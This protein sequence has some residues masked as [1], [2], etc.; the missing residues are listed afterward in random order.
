[1]LTTSFFSAE[2]IVAARDK[3]RA[4][5]EAV[6]LVDSVQDRQG[7]KPEVSTLQGKWLEI[8]WK[9]KHK[10]THEPIL[11]WCAG[12][13]VKVA[14][15]VNDMS[16]NRQNATVLTSNTVL[17]RWEADAEFEEEEQQAWFVLQPKKWNGDVQNSWR[18]D[19]RHL[20]AIGGVAAAIEQPPSGARTCAR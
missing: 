19:P 13:V 15:G 6:G 10:E 16:S 20:P 2:Q 14:D 9:Y 7:E 17:I 8:N 12:Q 11:I 18:L 1:M 5:R 3:E 4:R